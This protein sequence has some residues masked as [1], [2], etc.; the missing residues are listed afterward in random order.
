MIYLC[1]LNI[2]KETGDA[3]MIYLCKLN[4]HKATG[5]ANM[6]YLCKL[7]IHKETGDVNMIYLCKLN[8]HK[9][10]GDAN[11]ST[12]WTFCCQQVSK[13]G[14]FYYRFQDCTHTA[15]RPIISIICK[16]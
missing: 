11:M 15:L 2:H 10:T 16:I 13:H 5:D 7:N 3:N 4:I 9:E 6:I 12:K 8:I 1:K 14:V